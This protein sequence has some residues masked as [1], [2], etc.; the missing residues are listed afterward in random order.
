MSQNRRRV[1]GST[2]QDFVNG[3]FDCKRRTSILQ[4]QKKTQ[5]LRYYN[6]QVRV[7]FFAGFR[8]IFKSLFSLVNYKTIRYNFKVTGNNTDKK[9]RF[10]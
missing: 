7:R 10:I 4:N 8:V 5:I 2:N 1:R 3:S 6:V 9:L